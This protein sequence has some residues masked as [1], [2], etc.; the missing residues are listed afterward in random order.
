MGDCT[1]GLESHM[2]S[3]LKMAL[4]SPFVSGALAVIA[5]Y[6]LLALLS[7]LVQEVWLGGVSYQHSSTRVLILAGLCTPLCGLVAGLVVASIARRA[8]IGTQRNR[9]RP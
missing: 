4:E 7:A 3:S 8:A 5:G 1:L 6:A 2:V 9:L